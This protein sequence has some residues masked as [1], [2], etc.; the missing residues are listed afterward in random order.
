MEYAEVAVNSPA[1]R[2]HTF[3]YAVSAGTSVRVGQAVWVPFGAR[4]LQG[5][6]MGLSPLPA[7]DEVKPIAGIISEQ[8]LLSPARVRLAEWLRDYYLSPIFTAVSL[9][10]PPGFARKSLTY[11]SPSPNLAEKDSSILGDTERQL[12]ELVRE[13]GTVK[14]SSLEKSIGIMKA[15][16]GV[17][18]LADLGF[19]DRSYAPEPARVTDKHVPFLTLISPVATAAYLEKHGRRAPKQAALLN[20]LI[21][22]GE[23]VPQAEA[24]TQSDSSA[25]TL[26]ALTEHGLVKKELVRVNRD[27]LANIP[28]AA[29]PPLKLNAA[30]R[31]ALDRI[32][33]SLPKN[34]PGK[35][36]SFLL[37]GVTASGKTEVYLRALSAVIA[38]GRRG[39]MLVPEISLTPQTIARFTSRFPGRVAVLHSRLSAGEQHDEWHRVRRG[40][41]DVVIGPRSAVFAPQ[42]DLGLIILDE[43][44]EWAYKQQDQMPPYHCREVARKLADYSGATLIMGSATPDVETYYQSHNNRCHLLTLP[45]RAATPDGSTMPEVTI[46]DQRQELKAGNTGIFSRALRSGIR[47]TLGRREQVILFLNRRGGASYVQCRECGHVLRCRRCEVSLTPHPDTNDMVCH[48]CHYRRPIPKICPKCRG[49]KLDFL[50]TG[51]Q[52]L[53]E[54]TH[55]AFPD[56]RILR[57]DSDSAAGHKAHQQIAARFSNHEADILIGTQL[58]AK[59]LDLPMVTLVGVVNAD[60]GLFLPDFRAGERAFQLICQVAGR[61]GRGAEKGRV[62]VQT[63]SPRHYAVAAAAKQDY[64]QF[65]EKEI[66]FRRMLHNPP[67]SHLTRLIFSHANNGFAQKEALRLKQEIYAAIQTQGHPAANIIGPAP[68]FISRLRGRYRWQLILRADNPQSL[69]ERLTLPRG[70]TVNID[71]VGLA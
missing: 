67:F 56:A 44:H 52:K 29:Q 9:M 16:R 13:S 68:A 45:E 38:K 47:E 55:A 58:V 62:I 36:R 18:R 10:L 54:A 70:W 34:T 35:S 50:G 25:A 43:E 30:Q 3:S 40:E 23:A 48:H 19:I 46:I 4:T 15:R 41:C 57:W 21:S 1:A 71:P 26:R 7:V 53:E 33:A 22:K 5:I 65:Y 11:I 63:F 24:L 37:H 14:L 27:P 12:L 60:S 17:T 49:V 20:Y 51:T 66:G 32:I 2:R 69:L 8:P 64:R 61:A 28:P 39:I 42:P 6:V 59:G 31:Y